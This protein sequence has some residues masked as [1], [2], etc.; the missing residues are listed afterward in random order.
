MLCTSVF[1]L[2]HAITLKRI[3]TNLQNKFCHH[4]SVVG[5]VV[6]LNVLNCKVLCSIQGWLTTFIGRCSPNKGIVFYD[7]EPPS[8]ESTTTECGFNYELLAVMLL[9]SNL[10]AVTPTLHWAVLPELHF[11]TVEMQAANHNFQQPLGREHATLGVCQA[12]VL[13]VR[14]LDQGTRIWLYLTMLAYNLGSWCEDKQ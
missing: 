10:V 8:G 12:N 9:K 2:I 13:P 6:V 5:F 7:L 11:W 4:G 1:N 3:N 14:P